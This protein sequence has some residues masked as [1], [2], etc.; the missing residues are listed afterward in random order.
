MP[1]FPK[2]KAAA[3]RHST[4]H[5]AV[6]HSTTQEAVPKGM[7]SAMP[8]VTQPEA[9]KA[10]AFSVEVPE[11]ESVMEESLGLKRAGGKG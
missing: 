4:T 1:D 5:K 2:S 7:R 9:L 6:R 11:K 10:V 8:R 3:V